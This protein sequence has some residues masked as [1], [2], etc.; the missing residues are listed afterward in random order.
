MSLSRSAFLGDL[1]ATLFERRQQQPATDDAR[2]IE[3]MCRDL[4]SSRGEVSGLHLAASILASYRSLDCD[5]KIAFFRFLTDDLDID[6]AETA[7]LAA[8]YGKA[9][10]PEAFAAL[11]EPV[12]PSRQ[13]TA[14]Q[15]EP[16]GRGDRRA[17]GDAGGSAGP[18]AR[19]PVLRMSARPAGVLAEAGLAPG[20]RLV[21]Q[22]PKCVDALALYA[23]T[24]QA[25]AVYLPL[26]AA[27]TLG[28]LDYSF[29][30]RPHRLW[31]AAAPMP[32][33]SPRSPER[34]WQQC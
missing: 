5:G 12:E 31:C 29:P 26:N 11:Q 23:A 27:Y 15:A 10:S 32:T 14:A 19:A 13:G 18:P 21:A 1:M 33:P 6:P 16:I 20:D 7:A 2:A 17:G 30:T 24:L 8:G 22:T 28:E 25:G 3:T 9:R 4:L 34:S